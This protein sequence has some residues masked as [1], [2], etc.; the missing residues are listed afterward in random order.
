MGQSSEP[1]E[2][3]YGRREN[4]STKGAESLTLTWADAASI[5]VRRPGVVF[6]RLQLILANAGFRRRRALWLSQLTGASI[7]EISRYTHEIESD[8]QFLRLIRQRLREYTAYYPLPTDFMTDDRGGSLFFHSVS[9]YVFARLARPHMIVETGGTPGKSSAFLLRALQQNGVGELCTIDLPPQEYSLDEPTN[10]SEFHGRAP[11]GVGAAWLVP[12]SLR[13]RHSLII[14]DTRVVL[15]HILAKLGQIDLFIHDSDHS[16][17]HMRWELE[18]ARPY[19][20]N[21]GF[22]WSDDIGTNTAW[23]DFCNAHRLTPENFTSQGVARIDAR[24]KSG[25][26]RQGQL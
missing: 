25:H 10:S 24:H 16:Y 8:R 23:A 2:E 17:D 5:A 12:D 9:L 13:N 22:L 15:P 4:A 26:W 19:V 20:R 14:G 6:R 7:E 11:V 21:G 18:T 1:R 3:F